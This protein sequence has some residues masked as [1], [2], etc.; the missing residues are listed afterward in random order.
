MGKGISIECRRCSAKE[1]FCLGLGWESP[2]LES[3][4]E[5]L[6]P[7]KKE[8]VERICRDHNVT[9]RDCEW[10]LYE[11]ELC[12]R[13]FNRY[14]VKLLYEDDRIYETKFVCPRCEGK[15]KKVMEIPNIAQVPCNRCG[16]RS[17]VV[18]G[19]FLWD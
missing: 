1:N 2:S 5:F 12:K 15:L 16:E 4:I 18:T 9:Q 19:T 14:W 7:G 8:E 3:E 17:L 6:E 10:R 11:C 13:L